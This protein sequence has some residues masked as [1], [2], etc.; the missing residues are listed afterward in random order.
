MEWVRRGFCLHAYSLTKRVRFVRSVR[1]VKN[2]G[3][4]CTGSPRSKDGR[5][6]FV[7]AFV[8]RVP[9]LLLVHTEK[10]LSHKILDPINRSF[11]RLTRRNKHGVAKY[12]P[13]APSGND[14]QLPVLRIL[15]LVEV[16]GGRVVGPKQKTILVSVEIGSRHLLEPGLVLRVPPIIQVRARRAIASDELLPVCAHIVRKRAAANEVQIAVIE[17]LPKLRNVRKR[18]GGASRG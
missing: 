17:R 9:V 15:Q 16:C 3:V 6:W 11:V 2:D 18:G 7:F 5:D 8:L 13:L 10:Q 4:V 12:R 14:L 1:I